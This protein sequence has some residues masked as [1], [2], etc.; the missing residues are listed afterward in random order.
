MDRNG[1]AGSSHGLGA[2]P[3]DLIVVGSG[4][5]GH[6]AAIQAAK[7]GRRVAI[8]ERL[9]AVGGVCINTGTIPSKTLREAVLHLSGFRQRGLY[10]H[11][12]RVKQTI[13]MQDLMFQCRHVVH[14]QH[15]VYRSQFTRNGVD[16]LDGEASFLDPHTLRVESGARALTFRADR[17]VIATGTVPVAPAEFPP[18]GT[19]IITGDGILG[20]AAIPASLIVVGG[21]VVGMEYACIFAALGTQVTLVD[22]KQRLLEFVDREIVETLM[23]HMRDNRVSFRLGEEMAWARREAAG[24]RVGLRSH[25]E[26]QAQT[27]LYALG[28][29]GN[30]GGLDLPAAGLTADERGRIAV[31]ANFRTAMPHIFAAGDVIGFPNLA[32]T[33]MEQGRVASANAFGIPTVTVPSLFPYG[34]YTIP[35]ISFVGQTEEQLTAAGVPFEVGMALYREIARGG[36]IGDSTGRLKLIFRPDTGA[37]LGVHIIGEGA[38]ELV[39]IGQAVMALGGTIRYFVDH[40]FNYP[41]LAECYKVAALHGLNKLRPCYLAT[42]DV[43]E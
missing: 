21:G 4:P 23:Y 24:V 16:V 41:T 6:H 10:G 13:T 29:Q 42:A 22:G 17:F 12:Y 33:S 26:L 19:S 25:K 35:E 18:D 5:A 1:H 39:H 9:P 40:V 11:S 14:T 37:L 20:L 34:L 38:T 43:S 2:T 7:L 31:D 28:R 3:Y 8:V 36:I 15:E 32:S 27:L 30:V